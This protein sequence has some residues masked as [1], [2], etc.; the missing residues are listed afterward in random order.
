VDT[1]ASSIVQSGWSTVHAV[2]G[3]VLQ[4]KTRAGIL[5]A[6]DDRPRETGGGAPAS[7]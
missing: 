6:G 1:L 3:G 7:V 4:N 2:L 5:A